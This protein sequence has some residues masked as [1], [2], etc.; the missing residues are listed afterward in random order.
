MK[1]ERSAG[2]LLHPTSL[3]GNYGIGDLGEDAF[4]FIDFLKEAGQTLWQVFPLGPTGYGD[5][6]YQCFSA[7]AGNPLL[8]SPD[9]LTEDGFLSEKD[10]SEPQKFN[11][12]EIDF[13]EIINYKKS[14]LRKAFNNFKNDSNGLGKDFDEFCDKH[15]D[16]L[17]DFALFMA[18]KDF[19]NG[20]VWSKWEKGLIH[21]TEKALKEWKEKL[22][23]DIQYHKFVQFNFFRQWKAIRDYANKNGIKII[24]D[25]PIFIAYDSADLWA[26]KEIFSVDEDGKLETVAGVPPDYFSP[27]G[28]LWGN[29]LYRWKVMEKD[30]FLWMRKRF[31]SLYELIDI[32]RIDHFRGFDAY[33]EIPGDAKTAVKGRWVKAPGEKLFKSLIKHLGDVPILAEDLGVITP[34][35]EALRDKFNFPGMKILQ[36]AFG[37]D[38]ETKFLPHNFISN[39]VVLTGSHDNDTTRAYFEEAKK[40][41]NHIHEH[42]QIYLNYFGDD[43]VNELIRAA[44][45]SVANIV[46]IP[47]QDILN[48]GGEARMNFPGKLGG[49]W[50]W[51]FTWE[52][53]NENIAPHYKGLAVLYERPPK[54]KKKAKKIKVE[55]E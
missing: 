48:L 49:N 28:Q 53:M 55:E 32:V 33:W 24:G 14:L 25:M 51:R 40:E 39:C 35:V 45:A 42:V 13:G 23:D 27:T 22:S 41:E 5:S 54:K 17:E 47:M 38:M 26:N 44:Y 29:P 46:I 8:V 11:P 3:P 7:F 1:F 37:T 30:D 19:H 52:Q 21:R 36:F 18:A 12:A 50:A 6:P 20:D 16:W 15:K 2:I 43:I 9:K 34:E 4:K 31:A 10:L